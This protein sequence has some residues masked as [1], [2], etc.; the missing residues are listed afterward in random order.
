MSLVGNPKKIKYLGS[1]AHEQTH[2][3]PLDQLTIDTRG[4]THRKYS[5]HTVVRTK[6][7][8]RVSNP[9][10][11]RSDRILELKSFYRSWMGKEVDNYGLF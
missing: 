8:S 5:K 7:Y 3:L 9:Q 10:G 4:G 2:I 1:I 11:T 6:K